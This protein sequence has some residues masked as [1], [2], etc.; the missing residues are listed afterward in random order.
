MAKLILL[1]ALRA[2]EADDVE[3][4]SDVLGVP[5]AG[6]EINL[7][8]S[9]ADPPPAIQIGPD[10]LGALQLDDRLRSPNFWANANQL[11]AAIGFLHSTRGGRD[12]GEDYRRTI[13]HFLNPASTVSAHFVIGHA[14]E[15]AQMVRIVDAAWHAGVGATSPGTASIS[16]E[17]AQ[18]LPST[19][20][21]QAQYE[22]FARVA[23]AAFRDQSVRLPIRRI[24]VAEWLR[25]DRGWFGHDD[26]SASGR[27]SRGST[28]P[29][30][31]WSWDRAIEGARVLA[32]L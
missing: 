25:G 10:S 30:P 17:L 20:F 1:G 18:E 5:V 28:D 27:G 24:S 8:D 13:N 15:L 3:R 21:S 9:S 31:G 2:F 23:V 32:G 16:V 6:I 14:G 4:M 12:D 19:P 11:D 22:T 7:P 26:F 29:G